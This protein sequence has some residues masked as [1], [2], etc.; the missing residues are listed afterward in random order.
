MTETSSQRWAFRSRFRRG[1]FGWRSSRLAV[2][3]VKEAVAEIKK[4]ARSDPGRGAE[5]AVLFLERVSPALEEVDSS[6]GALGTAVYN[7][8][9]ALVPLV[10]GA[11]VDAKTRE[12]WLERLWAAHEADAIPYIEVLADFWGDL[13]VSKEIAAVWA[14][15]LLGTTR[16]ALSPDRSLHGHFHGT[17]ACLSALYRAA[18]YE[19]IVELL[20]A[21]AIWPYQRWAVKALVAM[22]QKAEAIRYAENCRGP[23]TPDRD[24]D[25]LCEEILLSSGL[26]EEAYRRYGLRPHRAT[27][28][29]ATF[30]ATAKLYPG[31]AP[32]ELLSDLV[33]TTPGQE[34]K[35]FATAKEI[36]LY[37]EALELATSSPCDPRTLARAAR[38]FADTHPAF[39]LGS[40]LAA[41]RWLVEGY[42]YEVT[43][44]DVWAAFGAT[45]RAAAIL[46]IL[47]ATREQIRLMITAEHAPGFVAQVLTG[48]LGG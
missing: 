47:D 48:E 27:S 25:E 29:L 1:S 24:V 28:Y 33:S 7:A 44:A 17:S 11:A 31:K 21:D 45:T 32:A 39:A 38:D 46:G 2:Q 36:G 41:L 23:W 6:S 10:A 35:W 9:Y 3:R 42:G 12:G 22:G 37:E 8:I 4:V 40:G 43:S 26:G 30:R 13:C 5:G 34:G 14:D 19:E 15:R 20:S 18:R 16:M